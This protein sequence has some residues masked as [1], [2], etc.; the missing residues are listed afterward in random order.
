MYKRNNKSLRSI[1]LRSMCCLLMAA[2]VIGL[3]P[4]MSGFA[5]P[6]SSMEYEASAASDNAGLSV[7][8]LWASEH[9]VGKVKFKWTAKDGVKVTGWNLEYRMRKIGGDNKWSDWTYLRDLPVNVGGAGENAGKWIDIPKDYVIEIHAQAVG[10]TTWSTGII[11]TPAGGKYQAMKYSRVKFAGTKQ[12]VGDSLTIGLGQSVTVTPDCDYPV[13]DAKKRP[14]LYPIHMLYDVADKSVISIRNSKGAAY[15]GGIIEGNAVIKGTKVGET[16]VVFRAPNGR[17][18]I[19]TVEV[20]NDKVAQNTSEKT[21]VFFG[22]DSRAAGSAWKTDKK[23]GTEGI[24]RS[25][26]IM[27]IRLNPKAGT[28]DLVSVYRDTML[29]V[30]GKSNDFQKANKAYADGGPKKA[31]QMLER[32]L[33]IKISG[34][35]VLNFKGVADIIDEL[36]GVTINIETDKVVGEGA[37]YGYKNVPQVMNHQIDE[38]NRCYGTSVKHVT[39]TGKQTLSG[40]QAVAYARVR[41]T[42]GGDMRRTVRQ[43]AVVTQMISK[44]KSLSRVKKLKVIAKAIAL[45]DTNISASDIKAIANT[46]STSSVSKKVGFPFYKHFYVKTTKKERLGKSNMFVPCN[47]QKNVVRLHNTV[48]GQSKYKASSTVKTLSKKMVKETKL[49]YKNRTKAYDNKF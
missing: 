1:L 2:L 39:R 45:V 15:K 34:Y 35:A 17:T 5:G 12:R 37:T 4:V 11:T 8:N 40:L 47:L 28:V 44:Y 10:D 3:M 27:I 7:K 43:R 16:T 21:F 13:K 46:I 14:K 29:D 26:S 6:D 49:D 36:G 48:Y 9:A 38:M 42:D 30:S 23:R 18:Q 22:S 20:V 31:V 41:Y 33:D 25:D 24:P 32:N 19:T